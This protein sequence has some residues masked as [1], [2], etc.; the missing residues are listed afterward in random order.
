MRWTKQ[1]VLGEYQGREFH[2]SDEQRAQDAQRFRRF[3]DDGWTVV[4]VWND[5]VN[6]DEARVALVLRVAGALNHPREG[7]DLN[8]VHPRFFSMRMLELAEIRARRLRAQAR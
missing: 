2:D 1:R 7:L 6:T 8:A 4:E 5:D 3:T